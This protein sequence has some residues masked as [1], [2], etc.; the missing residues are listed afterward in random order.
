MGISPGLAPKPGLKPCL[1]CQ[2]VRGLAG[3]TLRF[4]L[5]SVWLGGHLEDFTSWDLHLCA[6]W[7]AQMGHKLTAHE[8]WKSSLTLPTWAAF[9]V[10]G[11]KYCRCTCSKVRHG[12]I[13]QTTGCSQGEVQ[14]CL[15]LRGWMEFWVQIQCMTLNACRNIKVI[16]FGCGEQ[17]RAVFSKVECLC[18]WLSVPLLLQTW[19]LVITQP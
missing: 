5:D 17:G 11:R 7:K 16:E 14:K 4:L 8:Y 15:V 10:W 19:F 2:H 6:C 9:S 13:G 12:S 3:F 1:D 18:H